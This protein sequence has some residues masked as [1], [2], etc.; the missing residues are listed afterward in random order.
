MNTPSIAIR[1]ILQTRRK[2][3]FSVTP[4]GRY[5]FTVAIIDLGLFSVTVRW[6]SLT[7]LREKVLIAASSSVTARETT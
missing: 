1:C 6:G 4:I 3:T 2:K 7:M 5:N